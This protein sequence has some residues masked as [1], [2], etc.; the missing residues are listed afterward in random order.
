MQNTH[1]THT[2]PEGYKTLK[3]KLKIFFVGV[4]QNAGAGNN[5]VRKW[6]YA[7]FFLSS[8]DDQQH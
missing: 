5:V 2:K 6:S 7:V 8:L 4:D 3:T 1:K